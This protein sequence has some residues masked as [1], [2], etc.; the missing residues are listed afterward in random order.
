MSL[1]RPVYLDYNATTPV[2]PEVLQEMLPYFREKF[3]NAS[4][5][6][7]TYGWV[8]Q[9]AVE[10][11]RERVARLLHAEPVEIVFTSGATEA[12][13]LA[14]KGVFAAYR[15]RGNHLITVSTEHKAVLDCCKK[16]QQM[17][18]EVT[19]LPVE[20]DG[21][22][23]LSRLSEAIR[24]HTILIAVMYANNE[25]G[26]IHPV[27]QIAAIAH[28]RGVLC[29][30]DATQAVGKIPIDVNSSGCDL[31]TLSA[32]KFYGPKGVGALYV[33]RRNPRVRLV[34][35][36]DG[37]GHERNLR[38][39]TLNVPGIVGFGKACE[40]AE[41]SFTAP[42]TL[43][44]I[45]ALRNRLQEELLKNIPGARI[46]GNTAHRLPN[47]LNMSFPGVDSA[48]LMKALI[49]DIAISAGSACTSAIPEPSHVLSAM[50]LSEKDAYSAVRL[51]LGIFTT[52]E[53][54]HFSI[55][56]ICKAI[57]E[58]KKKAVG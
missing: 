54:I 14:L 40:L 53:E 13:N 25:T 52:E 50:G 5:H 37:G 9:E 55:E 33:R 27:E 2:H 12:I 32:H 24:D 22:I 29:M 18:A 11:A 49:Q 39:G 7:H 47:T 43:N 34:A 28:Q 30:S 31:L 46:N 56:K 19:Y 26:V 15:S 20:P 6:T 48:R 36:I 21:R 23:N 41:Q 45:A 42:D 1:V 38:S 10:K 51:S 16:L 8:A 57:G 35:Q 17:G 4:S 3:G 58:L 44:R